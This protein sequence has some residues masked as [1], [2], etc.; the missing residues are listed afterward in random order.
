MM[1]M[2]VET[3]KGI[4][5]IKI[6]SI[7]GVLLTETCH[8]SRFYGNYESQGLKIDIGQSKLF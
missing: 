6:L 2:R 4:A 5:T 7:L 3:G 1:N 8:C